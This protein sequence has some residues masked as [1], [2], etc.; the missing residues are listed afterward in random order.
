MSTSNVTEEVQALARLD[1]EG[2]RDTW[3]R[4]FGPP[5]ALRSPDLL[6]HALAWRLQAASV[7]TLDPETRRQLRR[8]TSSIPSVPQPAAGTRLAREWKG[9]RFEVEVTGDDFLHQG[10]RY[11]SLSEVARAITGVRWNGPRFFGLRAAETDR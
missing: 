9:E 10:K 1:L 2:L 11:A 7:G 8:P 5:P 3:R 4:R 6:R